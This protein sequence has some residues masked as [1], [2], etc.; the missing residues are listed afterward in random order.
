MINN[1]P[2]YDG[3]DWETLLRVSGKSENKTREWNLW[4][5]YY[6]AF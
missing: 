1:T 3:L 5:L 2:A 4:G 6:M